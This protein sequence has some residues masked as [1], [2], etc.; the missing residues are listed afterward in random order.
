[1]GVDFNKICLSKAGAYNFGLSIFGKPSKIFNVQ[2]TKERRKS[3]MEKLNE[4]MEMSDKSRMSK[5]GEWMK[6]LN[7]DI[8]F[9]LNSLSQRCI[10]K[11]FSHLLPFDSSYLVYFYSSISNQTLILPPFPLIL[12]FN[13]W[14]EE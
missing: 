14:V 13:Q 10:N 5:L 9:K 11:Q 6:L 12:A 4:I 8:A 7:K 1:M 3:C 2:V